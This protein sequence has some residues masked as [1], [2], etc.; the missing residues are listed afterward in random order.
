MKVTSASKKAAPALHTS[1]RGMFSLIL[2]AH[3]I[4]QKRYGYGSGRELLL[5]PSIQI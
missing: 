1:Y 2:I 3:H 4:A 5:I